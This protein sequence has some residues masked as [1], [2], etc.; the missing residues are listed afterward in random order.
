MLFVNCGQNVCFDGGAPMNRILP[1]FQKFMTD[2][3]LAHE[4]QIPFYAGWASKFIRFSNVRQS[5]PTEL[6]I[7]LFLDELKEIRK[8]RAGR[9]HRRKMPSNCT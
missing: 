2:R 7:Q 8:F 5:T 4:N 1:Q 9:L 3:K 6:K